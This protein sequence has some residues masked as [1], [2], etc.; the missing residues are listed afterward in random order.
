M[1]NVA[2]LVLPVQ[3]VG[4]LI[5]VCYEFLLKPSPP[6]QT[7]H[8]IIGLNRLF[9]LRIPIRSLRGKDGTESLRMSAILKISMRATHL[10]VREAGISIIPNFRISSFFYYTLS[11]CSQSS[12]EGSALLIFYC[13]EFLKKSE[14]FVLC[15]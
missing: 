14:Y 1:G 9:L 8:F 12:F 10:S 7:L 13:R 5:H 3:A 4:P 2:R 11:L 15:F 6:R